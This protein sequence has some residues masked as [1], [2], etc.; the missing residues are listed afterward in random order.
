MSIVLARVDDRLIH[1]QVVTSWVAHSGGNR[2]VIVDDQMANDAF[3]RNMLIRLAPI[4]TTVEVYT[5]ESAVEPLIKYQDSAGVKVI[6]LVK[7]P[8]PILFL[9]EKGVK[10]TE[11]IVGGMGIHGNR[12]KLYRNISA[13]DAER[14]TMKKLHEMGCPVYCR[15]LPADKPVD[16]MQIL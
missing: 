8:G 1:G 9:V 14:S 3:M 5:A 15:I 11:L 6:I 10:I 12:R 2:I 13:D 16:V 7:S 4:G